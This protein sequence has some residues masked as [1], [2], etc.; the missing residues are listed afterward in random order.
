MLAMTSILAEAAATSAISG[1]IGYG[2]ATLGAGIGIGLIG[3]KAAEST[4]RNPSA[5]VSILVISIVLAALIEG[6]ALIA[7]LLK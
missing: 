2:L 5:W 3:A 7:I 1:N 4:G 6:V